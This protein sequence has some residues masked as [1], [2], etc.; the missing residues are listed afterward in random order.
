MK[1]NYTNTLVGNKSVKKEIDF[2]RSKSKLYG[3]CGTKPNNLIIQLDSGEGR[4]AIME[5]AIGVFKEFSTI[6]FSSGR[7]DFIECKFDGTLQNYKNCMVQ[8]SDAAEY[9]NHFYGGIAVDCTSISNH[10]TEKH[11]DDF[12]KSFSEICNNAWVVFFFSSVPSHNEEK[13]IKRL[14]DSIKNITHIKY[15]AYTVKELA[16]I[17]LEKLNAFGIGF[18]TEKVLLPSLTELLKS[19]DIVNVKRT[20][21]LSVMALDFI[22]YEDSHPIFSVECVEK[23]NN[24]LGK[25]TIVK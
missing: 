22:D 17:F 11:Y 12:I 1:T 25:E 7:D 8:I 14:K 19:N 10:Y 9:A 21:N 5:Y 16:S 2:F 15:E 6:D 4:T 3:H 23:L 24:E 18:G 20:I 13:L